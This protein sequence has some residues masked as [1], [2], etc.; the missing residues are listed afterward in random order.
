L[1]DVQRSPGFGL[2]PTRRRP[3]R[4]RGRAHSAAL[5]PLGNPTPVGTIRS[6]GDPTGG[7]PVAGRV[8]R[9]DGFREPLAFTLRP[10][11]NLPSRGPT[12]TGSGTAYGSLAPCAGSAAPGSRATSG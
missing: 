12:N 5:P 3:P 1:R 10:C 2:R 8:G 4:G 7:R 9:A 11:R 6:T